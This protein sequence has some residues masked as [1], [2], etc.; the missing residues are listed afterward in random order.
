MPDEP[1]KPRRGLGCGAL[2]GW[3]LLAAVLAVLALGVTKGPE[4][5][6]DK[7]RDWVSSVNPFEEKTV[8]RTG[9]SVLQSLTEISEFR[10]ARAHYETVVDIEKDSEYWPDWALGE[11]ILYVGKGEVD[12]FVDFGQLD[13]RRVVVSEDGTSVSVSLP[14][15]TVGEPV[16]DLESSYVFEHDEG[17]IDDLFTGSEIEREAQLKAVDQMTAAATGDDKLVDMA[18]E[19]TASMLRGLLGALGY[20]DITITFDA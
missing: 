19:S 11:R 8:D 6:W 5:V 2:L 13:E 4:W 17:F 10:A 12:A 16:L 14:A 20:T 3:L 9:P 18:K 1:R 15:P 7:A